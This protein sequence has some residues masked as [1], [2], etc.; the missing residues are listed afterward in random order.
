MAEGNEAQGAKVGGA[1]QS[2]GLVGLAGG[3]L[4]D[5]LFC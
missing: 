4:F 1:L 3:L 2:F 5:M